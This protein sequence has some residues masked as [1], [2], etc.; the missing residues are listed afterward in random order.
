M[1]SRAERAPAQTATATLG[2][3]APHRS[4]CGQSQALLDGP[5]PSEAEVRPAQRESVLELRQPA[6][7]WP[8]PC[9]ERNARPIGRT[10]PARRP[11]PRQEREAD[12][13]GVRRANPSCST[14]HQRRVDAR[15]QK[16]RLWIRSSRVGQ[17]DS[18]AAASMHR[19]K[20]RSGHGAFARER[21]RRIARCRL[22]GLP[23]RAKASGRG[24]SGRLCALPVPCAKRERSTSVPG[25]ETWKNR[26]AAPTSVAPTGAAGAYTPANVP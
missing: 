9:F 11:P 14:G 22:P 12:W 13:Q 1:G 23:T 18:H 25:P 19:A 24:E 15:F 3:S 21:M 7:G 16:E 17:S 8:E 2:S 10:E 6:H 26:G 5:A 4:R 20:L